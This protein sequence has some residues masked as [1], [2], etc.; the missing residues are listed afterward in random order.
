MRAAVLASTITAFLALGLFTASGQAP[1]Q[2]HGVL[3]VLHAGQP[4]NLKEANGRYEIGI[5]ENVPGPLG[6]KV[7]E[8]GTDYLVLEDIT[9]VTQTR[10]PIY[11]IKA[12][13]T[14]KV[15]K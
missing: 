6:Q 10:L 7:I 15:G 8:V 4:V 2:S 3:A 1:V 12:I 9:G 11:S 14:L 13:T 5:I